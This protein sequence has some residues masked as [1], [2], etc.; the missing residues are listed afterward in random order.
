MSIAIWYC[1][2]DWKWWKNSVLKYH[3][4]PSNG[5][6][7]IAKSMCKNVLKSL[8]LDP[9]PSN[10]VNL[11]AFQYSSCIHTLMNLNS[12]HHVDITNVQMY[13]DSFYH[14]INCTLYTTRFEPK[15]YHRGSSNSSQLL[16]HVFIFSWIILYD[17]QS[18]LT[19][20]HFFLSSII[21]RCFPVLLLYCFLWFL[22][23]CLPVCFSCH[24]HQ[25][26]SNQLPSMDCT[27]SS[28]AQKSLV[29]DLHRRSMP[30]LMKFWKTTK[31]TVKSR[32]LC[33]VFLVK[34]CKW[35]HTCS[36]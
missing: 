20:R 32:L 6:N 11:I 29:D 27:N 16:L 4:N 2:N 15:I 35:Y 12:L 36:S 26:Q 1:I 13:L 28:Y 19:Y 33:L 7:L 3:M 21:R 18:L 22:W 8:S 25:A 10:G 14:M 24:H 31:K 9:N 23:F 34:S 30:T 5:V 17:N